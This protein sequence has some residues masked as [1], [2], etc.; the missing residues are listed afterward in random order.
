M[1]FGVC[2]RDDG[3]DRDGRSGARRS[4]AREFD[5]EDDGPVGGACAEGSSADEIC[6]A[7]RVKYFL[8]I[9]RS[10]FAID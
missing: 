6:L 10:F 5:R 3:G 7:K 8:A 1:F 9:A 2:G 4:C